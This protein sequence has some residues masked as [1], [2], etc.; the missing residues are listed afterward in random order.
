MWAQNKMEKKHNNSPTLS[1]ME[2]Y[3]QLPTKLAGTEATPSE[4]EH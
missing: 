2:E 1:E 3:S 4:A